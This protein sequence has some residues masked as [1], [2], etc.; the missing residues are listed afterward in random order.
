MGKRGPKTGGI[1][2][3]IEP[4][5]KQYPNPPPG[6]SKNARTV[7]LR[8]T[9]A[10]EPDHFRPYQ[11]DLLRVYCEAAAAHK[12]AMREVFKNGEVITQPNGVT[13]ESPWIGISGKMGTT[14]TSL[15]TKLGL[16]VNST[17]VA[18][19]KI[20]DTAKPKSKRDGLLFGGK[21]DIEKK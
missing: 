5:K 2:R 10:F 8:I 13:K 11:Y 18:R 17:L 15:S 16:N 21:R 19:G 9:R 3:V 1:R 7:W 6:T 12:K 14:M 4:V 20:K